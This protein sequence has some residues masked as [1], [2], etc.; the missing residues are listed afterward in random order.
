MKNMFCNT[1]I[2]MI[3]ENT[4]LFRNMRKDE[5]IKILS[6]LRGRIQNYPRHSVIFSAGSCI[7]ELGLVLSGSVNIEYN[8]LWGN[9]TII[10]LVT[11]GDVFTETYAYF[12]DIPLI[13]DVTANSSTQILFLTMPHP[14]DGI[15]NHEPWFVR[16]IENLLALSNRKNLS[17]ASRSLY[18]SSKSVRGRISTYLNS[19]AV[20]KGKKEFD[21]PFNR[22]QLADYLNL[23][24]SALSK[25]LGRMR[26]E[27]LL[28]FHKNHFKLFTDENLA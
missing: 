17:L 12:N 2:S 27:G 25:E 26:D 4:V 16:F 9:R 20:R 13:F 1:D 18:T 24:R 28:A 6:S 19:Q 11:E 21:I 3:P 23:D 15:S 7:R 10:G 14:N 8:D 22:Q 5:I